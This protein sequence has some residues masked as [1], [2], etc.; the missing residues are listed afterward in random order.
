M[1]NAR[2]HVKEDITNLI[3][4]AGHTILWLTSYSTDLN[5]IGHIRAWIKRLRQDW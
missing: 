5:P 3:E 2:F 4:Q 1:D